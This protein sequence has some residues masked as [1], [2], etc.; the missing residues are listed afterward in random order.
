MKLNSELA[1]LARAYAARRVRAV[2]PFLRGD[3]R[4][5][6]VCAG[7][8]R[9]YGTTC[10][11]LPHWMLAELKASSENK[12]KGVGKQTRPLLNR[13]SPTLG[14]K[15]VPGDGISTLANSPAFIAHKKDSGGMPQTGDIVIIQANPYKQAHEHTFVFL[16]QI[17]A[18]TWETGESG[19]ARSDAADGAM[20]G[21]LKQRKMSVINGKWHADAADGIPARY[22]QGWLDISNLDYLTTRWE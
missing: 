15:L 6:D 9:G 7:Y 8:G 12:S 16:R 3:A 2:L 22:V 5:K 14:A 19:Q 13:N 10:S 1:A 21:V 20:D 18:T 17:D 11:F 4:E